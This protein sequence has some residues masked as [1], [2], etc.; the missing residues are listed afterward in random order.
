MITSWTRLGTSLAVPFTIYRL[1]LDQVT[2]QDVGTAVQRV[3]DIVVRG[4]Y[5]LAGGLLL[6]DLTLGL[7]ATVVLR[8][9][10]GTA[11]ITQALSFAVPLE[12]LDV[13][14][15]VWVVL[16]ESILGAVAVGSLLETKN[17]VGCILP[18]L[19]R[20]QVAAISVS[21]LVLGELSSFATS[22][23]WIS[24][25][26]ESTPTMDLLNTAIDNLVEGADC[27]AVTPR[28]GTVDL[29]DLLL[30]PTVARAYGASGLEPYG[31]VGPLLKDYIDKSLLE[32]DAETG[33]LGLVE[34]FV[35]P[36]TNS[37]SDEDGSNGSIV[38][39]DDLL[40][41]DQ[42]INL[43]DVRAR[44]E[45][46]ISNVRIDN[47][48][49]IV[50]P[51]GL[52]DPLREEAHR[53]SNI[54]TIG[55][56]GQPLRLSLGLVFGFTADDTVIRNELNVQ[57][58][59]WEASLSTIL[60]LRVAEEYF[61]KFPLGSL[62]DI[63]C[64]A[65]MLHTPELDAQGVRIES[66][67]PSLSLEDVQVAI[68]GLRLT[69]DCL[70]CSSPEVENISQLL[71]DPQI[72]Q[73][74][75][76]ALQ[77]LIDF[78][79]SFAQDD[80]S[81]LQLQ[82]DRFLVAATRQ[83][84]F[85][86]EYDPNF[87]EI[88]YE[89]L[90]V[91]DSTDS[92]VTV[93]LTMLAVMSGLA[94]ATLAIVTLV[95]A[96]VSRRNRKWMKTLP[97]SQLL[98][99]YSAQHQEQAEQQ[100]VNRHSSS[101]FSSPTVPL[102]LRYFVPLV[103]LGNIGLFLSGH[104]S[105]GGSV[106]IYIEIA[107]EEIV[108]DNFYNFSIAQSALE[109]WDAGGKELAILILL[110]SGVWPYTKLAITICLWF[111][112]PSMVSIQRRGSILMWLDTLGK[113]SVRLKPTQAT[114][115]P[116]P[117]FSHP[118]TD[119]IGSLRLQMM[120]VFVMIISIVAFRV[121]IKSPDYSFLPENF[122]RINLLVAPLWGLYANMTA[123]LVSQ[124]SSHLIIHYHRRV[125]AAG[126]TAYLANKDSAD[127][128]SGDDDEH[129]EAP[130]PVRVKSGANGREDE[131]ALYETRF[132]R[133]HRGE[134]ALSLRRMVHP[135]IFAVSSVLIG[136]LLLGYL[137]PSFSFENLGI[138]GVA[139]EFRQNF[140]QAT[141]DYSIST[142]AQ[143]FMDQGRFLGTTRDML[144]HFSIVALL[145]T[146]TLLI[147]YAL[148]G[149]ILVQLWYPVSGKTRN[150]LNVAIE[151]L[152]AWQYVEVY[153]L[154]VVVA[155]WQ[156]GDISEYLVNPY[157]GSLDST[158]AELVYYG[159]LSR[160][161]AQCFRVRSNVEPAVYT[162]VAAAVLLAFLQS[163]VTNAV[164]QVSYQSTTLALQKQHAEVTRD[165]G[166]LSEDELR[167]KVHPVPV[168]FTDRFR[169]LLQ[170]TAVP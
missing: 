14:L 168:L 119:Y 105:Q 144:G 151:S 101:L 81:F 44:L 162:F 154:S 114:Q 29:R 42:G 166:K 15:N 66:S 132:F 124:F 70:E 4:A 156:V 88:T 1:V 54:A 52:L 123:Q 68:K 137:L 45:L 72:A 103:L 77:D 24:N 159:I 145:V 164:R 141:Y 20:L 163:L 46:R 35:Y 21:E 26:L 84:E 25:M 17:V 112:P 170:T 148:I 32:A 122:Y 3:D 69:M 10:N 131:Y 38:L 19:D 108:I 160:D 67:E 153:L 99:I 150:R 55:T 7:D 82:I 143:L 73:D 75:T 65:S 43:G 120:D 63:Q 94:L 100:D 64:L 23:G 125:E 130:S 115:S 117:R 58:E 147:P 18:A 74:A 9:L 22:T 142:I 2:I 134:R 169:W 16:S 128:K 40:D 127:P 28:T 80:E 98:A 8:P 118:H 71:Q 157:C 76:F 165:D 60:L 149:M 39:E 53:T 89:S 49:S 56:E 96:I 97:R 107:G 167:E 57:V 83:C 33:Q 87:D 116:T 30:D 5:S 106:R 152:S 92:S 86:D 50:A 140:E 31:D 135:L 110:F 111:A 41:I 136:L 62:F 121:T 36:L 37:L 104:L 91:E 139:I 27:P 158:F 13:D 59:V 78:A 12:R 155:G 51:I 93:L 113:W 133:P 61:L 161:D 109:L 102:F 79:L 146:S 95:Q 34:Q 85:R 138:V 90:V 129:E 11:S 126:L 48:E 47:L 6:T